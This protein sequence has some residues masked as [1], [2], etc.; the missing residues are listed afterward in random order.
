MLR[1]CLLAGLAVL[2]SSLRD[3]SLDVEPKCSKPGCGQYKKIAKDD[4]NAALR[5]KYGASLVSHTQPRA[6]EISPPLPHSFAFPDPLTPPTT[7]SA[8]D[9][10]SNDGDR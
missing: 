10:R 1:V 5:D 8:L 2:A 7:R 6:A 4:Q 9:H 3:A